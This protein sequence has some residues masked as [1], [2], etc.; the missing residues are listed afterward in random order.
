[1]EYFKSYHTIILLK[2]GF[3]LQSPIEIIII[4]A[5]PIIFE[6]RNHFI[7]VISFL[8]FYIYFIS[9]E[10]CMCPHWC[11]THISYICIYADA[12][13]HIHK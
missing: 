13:A 5:T 8:L 4:L 7:C 3:P 1:M 2:T 6:N 12:C 10:L 9:K 11:A